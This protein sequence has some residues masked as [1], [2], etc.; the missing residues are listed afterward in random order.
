[1]HGFQDNAWTVLLITHAAR[2]D[3]NIEVNK[4]RVLGALNGINL[5]RPS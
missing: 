3:L 4:D 1:M 5:Q 2:R